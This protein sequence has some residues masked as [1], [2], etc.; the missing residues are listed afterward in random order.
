MAAG[1][2][3]D[4]AVYVAGASITAA[5][6]TS[7]ATRQWF[8]R[9]LLPVAGVLFAATMF[10]I[11]G[12]SGVGAS[13]FTSGGGE[14][15]APVG[16]DGVAGGAPLGGWAL[17]A[18]NLLSLPFLW[19][20]VWGTWGLGWLD[21]GMPDIVPWAAVSAFVVVGFAG[22]ARLSGRKAFSLAGVLAVLIVLPVYVLT[23]GNDTVG[24]NL[25]PRYLLPLLV[26]FVFLLVSESKGFDTLRFTRVQTFVILG[27]LALAQLVALQINIRRYVT[28]ADAQ[29]LNLD[30]GAEWWWS[31]VAIG[32]MAMWLIGGLAYAALLAV[33]WPSLRRASV[34]A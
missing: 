8:L 3:G 7:E 29:G 23:A 6:L 27:A 17:A 26:L 34:H 9:A 18:Y 12:Q 1:S 14:A 33:L 24:V 21:T 22:I 16:D 2:R 20:G 28:G 5:I 15:V 32:P 19:T 30:A 11:S 13:G 4:A 25:Q 10:A 31:G